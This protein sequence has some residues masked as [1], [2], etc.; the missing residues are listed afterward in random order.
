MSV[1]RNSERLGHKR[2]ISSVAFTAV[3][4]VSMPVVVSAEARANNPVETC[5]TAGRAMAGETP[6]KGDVA[7]GG[8]PALRVED[9]V[10]GQMAPLP[11]GREESVSTSDEGLVETQDAGGG[12][13][14]DVRGR[15]R[16]Y[17]KIIR[18]EAGQISASC[19]HEEQH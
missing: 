19:S 3:L 4:A 8:G 1:C 15:F 16:S 13:M 10:T 14:V 11:P 6:V 2:L 18:D 9:P 12:T 7:P 5:E 17:L